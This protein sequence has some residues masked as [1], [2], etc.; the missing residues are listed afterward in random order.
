MFIP[1]RAVLT[2]TMPALFL[3]ACSSSPEGDRAASGTTIAVTAT[4][5]DCLI[6]QAT[7]ASGS[8]EFAVTNSG[9]E[10]TEI[11]V[12][13]QSGDAFTTVISEVENIGPGV[14]RD[15]S[16]DLAAGTYEVAC[17]PGQTGDGIRTSLTVT[18]DATAS[19]EST[20][21]LREI[22]LS[23]DTED[24]LTGVQGQSASSGELIE[25]EVAN[26]TGST[27][28]FEVKR[29]D[30]TVAGEIEIEPDMTGD[31][32]LDISVAGTW[33]LI[34]EGGAVETVADFTVE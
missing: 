19:T 24:R 20:G 3:V 7:V 22:A 26:T 16:V 33:S 2:L 18:G 32:T 1:S 4:D 10:V 8:I 13:G 25:F 9:N 6:D 5:T 15:M 31:L 17:K 34:V 27:R 29:P 21:A 11:Y 28:I 23:I 12:Y 14:T 30:G